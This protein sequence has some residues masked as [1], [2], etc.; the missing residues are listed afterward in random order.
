[1]P[2]N[3]GRKI[4]GARN[5]DPLLP[6]LSK[7]LP[8]PIQSQ[9]NMDSIDSYKLS[10]AFQELRTTSQSPDYPRRAATSTLVGPSLGADGAP[11]RAQGPVASEANVRCF[12]QSMLWCS[13]LGLATLSLGGRGGQ[14]DRGVTPSRNPNPG[15]QFFG[16]ESP[17]CPGKL[18]ESVEFG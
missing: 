13:D 11:G 17:C 10:N 12:P 5:S 14:E 4:A 3:T 15:G 6:I 8:F 18:K 9:R 7:R 1:M 2:R 16:Q